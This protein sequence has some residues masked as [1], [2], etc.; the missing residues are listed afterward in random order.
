M[1][2]TKEKNGKQGGKKCGKLKSY[3]GKTGVA[4]HYHKPPV[5]NFLN[6]PQKSELCDYQ[7]ALKG[8]T[9]GKGGSREEKVSIHAN[10]TSILKYLTAEERSEKYRKAEMVSE[11]QS[12]IMYSM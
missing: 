9:G 5:Y 10:I 1:K 3:V 6:Q 11:I 12:R 8:K 4:L 7:I 2:L